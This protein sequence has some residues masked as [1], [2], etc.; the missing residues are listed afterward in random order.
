[1][2]Q[3]LINPPS[4]NNLILPPNPFNILPTMAV[5]QADPTR[6]DKNYSP[7]SLDPS[8]PS[9]ISTPSMN[10]S[11]IEG[12]ETP[13]TSTDNATL[14]SEEEPR[15]NYWEKPSNET[16]EW[17]EEPRR[18]VL[19]QCSPSIPPPPKQKRRSASGCRLENGGSVAGC[20]RGMRA[21]SSKEKDI[22]GPSTKYIETQ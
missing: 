16:F 7:Q 9:S 12:W 21:T 2:R 13:H 22:P 8:D 4:L 20:L 10:L 19:Q 18:S 3:D 6:N 11:A 17:D 14:Y 1:M 15:R 5:I